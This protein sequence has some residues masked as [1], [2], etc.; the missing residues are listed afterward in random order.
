MA[1]LFLCRKI[2]GWRARAEDVR[3]AF[4]RLDVASSRQV[5]TCTGPERKRRS[6]FP[7]RADCL[8]CIRS[9]ARN[10]KSILQPILRTAQSLSSG[11]AFARPVGGLLRTRSYLLKH[12]TSC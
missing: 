5:L 9:S 12:N 11:R 3:R 4:S 7:I 10:H 2:T 8:R 6:G 1:L